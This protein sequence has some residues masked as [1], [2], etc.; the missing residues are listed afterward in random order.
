MKKFDEGAILGIMLAYIFAFCYCFFMI[1]FPIALF[2]FPI[3]WIFPGAEAGVEFF[4][5]E[6]LP[7]PGTILS[8]LMA[9]YYTFKTF[10]K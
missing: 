9:F 5:Y 4:L 10:Q 8:L 1:F 2:C 3:V 6:L 7:W